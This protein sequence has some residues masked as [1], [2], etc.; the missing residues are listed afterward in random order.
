[1]KKIYSYNVNGIRSAMNKDLAGWIKT[2]DADIIC[3]QEIKAHTDQIPVSDFESLGFMTYWFP[4]KKKG[5]SGVGILTKSKPDNVVYGMGI[6][7]YDDEG[8]VIRAEFGDISV[9]NVYH[10]SG[11]MGEVRQAF[12][13]QWLDDFLNY[14]N[15]LK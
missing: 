10:P 14:I 12:K 6:D 4:A 11:T 5:Y 1:M 13:I 7:K 3:F 9:I 8:R 2:S 15:D